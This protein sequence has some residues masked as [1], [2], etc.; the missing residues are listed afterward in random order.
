VIAVA[1]DP[2]RDITEL[3]RVTFVMKNGAVYIHDGLKLGPPTGEYRH[4]DGLADT[5]GAVPTVGLAA[6]TSQLAAN[7]VLIAQ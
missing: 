6:A 7:G 4:V 1:G 3:E 2:L 5:V